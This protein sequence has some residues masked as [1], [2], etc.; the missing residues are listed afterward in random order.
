MRGITNSQ[1]ID[2]QYNTN[3]RTL[4]PTNHCYKSLPKPSVILSEQ[5]SAVILLKLRFMTKTI[6]QV[7]ITPTR[8]KQRLNFQTYI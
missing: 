7:R 2:G 4:L 5:T 6:L 8:R 1:Y 3:T